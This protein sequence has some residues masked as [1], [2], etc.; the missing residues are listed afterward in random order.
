MNN[1]LL[2]ILSVIGLLALYWVLFGQSRYN[3]MMEQ[4]EKNNQDQKTSK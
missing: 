1:G 2:V 3:K 4:G